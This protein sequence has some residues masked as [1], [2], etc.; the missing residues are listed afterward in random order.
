[1]KRITLALSSLVFFASLA[2]SSEESVTYT[3]QALTGLAGDTP[4]FDLIYCHDKYGTSGEPTYFSFITIPYMPPTYD[5]GGHF[6]H[7]LL[8]ASGI[9]VSGMLTDDGVVVNLDTRKLEVAERLFSGKPSDLIRFAFECVRLTANHHRLKEF[10]LTITASEDFSDKAEEL[11]QE[12][13]SH[14]RSK[15]FVPHPAKA[16]GSNGD[17]KSE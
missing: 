1:M 15:P 2:H 8:S 3:Y 13:M 6:D 17:N 16:A 5:E 14:D 9:N 11:R 12:F 7:N 10:K 4:R